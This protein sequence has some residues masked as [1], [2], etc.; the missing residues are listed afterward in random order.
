MSRGLGLRTQLLLVVAF[1]ELFAI[2]MGLSYW[3]QFQAQERLERSFREDLVTLSKLPR[4]RDA[5]RRLDDSTDRYLLSGDRKSLERRQAALA[6]LRATVTEISD[7]LKARTPDRPLYD[8]DRHVASYLAQEEQWLAQKAS[9]RLAPADAARIAALTTPFN[10]IAEG[11]TELKEVSVEHL[12][13]RRDAVRSTSNWA[14]VIV[15]VTGIVCSLLLGV[16]LSRHLIRPILDLESKARAWR[17]GE[18]WELEPGEAG[19]E[20]ASLMR[21]IREMTDR[22]NLQY[23]REKELGEIKTQLVSTIS[24]EFNNA[25][26][27]IVGVA[28][29]LEDSDGDSP[30]RRKRYY[31]MIR[32][33]VKSLTI[34]CS[35]LINMGRLESGRFAL[36]ARRVELSQLLQETALRL[37]ILSYQKK[38]TVS[39]ELPQDPLPVRADPEVLS[40]VVT[41][42]LSNAIKFSH[43]EGKIEVFAESWEGRVRVGVRDHGE[44]F[45]AQN[46]PRLFQ[47]FTQIDSTSTRRAGGTG[48]GLVIC[49]GI[50]E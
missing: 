4:L 27:I 43:P 23:R 12:N 8:L 36:N 5:L 38:Q 1:I 3:V 37:E 22:L 42:L 25:M 20:V 40:L 50:V 35:N 15:I 32:D 46:L 10:E 49:R 24:H 47:K 21:N 16:F 17:L 31:A 28:S 45:A 6:D 39:V 11:L 29:L 34:A 44:G 48:L 2:G 41:N 7:I 9:G 18:S 33:N 13:R 19:P 30:E 26:T 14:L